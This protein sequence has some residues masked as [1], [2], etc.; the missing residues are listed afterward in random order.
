MIKRILVFLIGA[1]MTF[2]MIPGI[3]FAADTD[4][5]NY[6]PNKQGSRD[7]NQVRVDYNKDADYIG[8][9]RFGY[10]ER[11]HLEPG[12]YEFK[13]WTGSLDEGKTASAYGGL[14]TDGRSCDEPVNGED[15]YA[16]DK[17]ESKTYGSV[18]YKVKESGKYY[19]GVYSKMSV[20]ADSV[21]VWFSLN[22]LQKIALNGEME[23]SRDYGIWC[24]PDSDNIRRY[25]IE[26]NVTGEI[27]FKMSRKSEIRIYD[28]SGSKLLSKST[29]GKDKYKY[30]GVLGGK[31]YRISIIDNSDNPKRGY[32]IRQ[33]LTMKTQLAGK[34]KKTARELNKGKYYLALR[35]AGLE[36]ARWFKFKTTKSSKLKISYNGHVSD[37]I[38]LKILKSNGKKLIKNGVRNI[39]VSNPDGS[40]TTE[41]LKKG[42]YYVKVIRGTK[43]T[44]GWCKVKWN[45]K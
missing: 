27:W 41:K 45:Y 5:Y 32:W 12:V 39:T 15:R 16:Y 28:S 30:F 36:D 25:K 3:S 8:N 33:K 37:R 29:T 9:G 11:V 10:S 19:L 4:G 6:M 17:S 13:M 43:Y 14:F 38:V 22:R 44:S 40:F 24:A 42:T 26:P 35:Y 18:V 31:T 34:S 2:A 7:A 21:R 20:E 1:F 23:S